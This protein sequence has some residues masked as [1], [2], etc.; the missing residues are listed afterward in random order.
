M[1]GICQHVTSVY[2]MQHYSCGKFEIFTVVM[3][4]TMQFVTWLL[5]FRSIY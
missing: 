1:H 5:T 2:K 3:F 4:G